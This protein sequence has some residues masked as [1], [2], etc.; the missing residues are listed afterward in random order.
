MLLYRRILP[1]ICC[2]RGACLLIS[3]HD[4]SCW[5]FIIIIFIEI[6]R[7]F[8]GRSLCEVGQAFLF[9]DFLLGLNVVNYLEVISIIWVFWYI[10]N[11]HR[12]RLRVIVQL[13]VFR[14]SA[15]LPWKETTLIVIGWIYPKLCLMG[16]PL[17]QRVIFFIFAHDLFALWIFLHHVDAAMLT[18]GPIKRLLVD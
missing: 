8:A 18:W 10:L 5:V 12:D 13:A 16:F 7:I 17:L 6:F 2:W 9:L 11:H 14:L 4:H 15:W 1:R 3:E